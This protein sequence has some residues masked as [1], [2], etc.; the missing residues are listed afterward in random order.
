MF[1]TC[2]CSIKVPTNVRNVRSNVMLVL[3]SVI[4]EPSNVRKNKGTTNVNKSIVTYDIGTAQYEDGA[5]K[6]ERKKKG[7]T[8]CD[9]NIATCDVNATQYED[10]II[11]CEKKKGNYLM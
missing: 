7:S 11:K 6:Y 3:P 2:K 1:N 5:I 8:K 10:N 4:M 9:K